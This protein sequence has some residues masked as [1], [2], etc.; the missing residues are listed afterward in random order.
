MRKATG[1]WITV[2]LLT[3]IINFIGCDSDSSSNEGEK[4]TEEF[5]VS[6][7]LSLPGGKS[8]TTGGY[9]INVNGDSYVNGTWSS[10][11]T[12]DYSF[13]IIPGTYNDI[14]INV[15]NSD[16]NL[17]YR[18]NTISAGLVV[19]NADI[20]DFNFNL[21]ETVTHTVSG[22]VNLPDPD[23]LSDG[24]IEIYINGEEYYDEPWDSGESLDYSFD[25]LSGTYN[26]IDIYAYNDMSELL[27]TY[28]TSTGGLV[29]AGDDVDNYDFTLGE[30]ETYTVSGNISLPAGE[31]ITDGY[32]DATF[33]G[34][35]RGEYSDSWSSGDTLAYSVEV[36]AGTYDN[37]LIE[38]SDE[39][40]T[41][42]YRY[43]NAA[44][45]LEVSADVTGYDFNL[46]E[47]E[48]FTVSGTITLPDEDMLTNGEFSIEIDGTGFGYDDGTWI[49]GHAA[50]YSIELEAGTYD[51]VEIEITDESET[52]LY[53]YRTNTQGL[54]IT[55]DTTV[56][57]TVVDRITY[58][59]S[60]TM[61]LPTGVILTNGH[62][63]IYFEGDVGRFAEIMTGSWT[64]GNS[65]QY[66]I[67]LES[68]SYF[69]I[70]I[71]V[72]DESWDIIYY[73]D[74]PEI[75]TLGSSDITGVDF[76]IE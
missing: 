25:I 24:V 16:G 8:L 14:E 1:L 36:E 22:T 18:Y 75:F 42:R 61:T 65:Q 56:N 68:G 58:T 54:T 5:T 26:D 52:I 33:A 17:L 45:G 7:T 67:E 6:G 38:V 41:V 31:E 63:D 4:D 57:F 13:E 43:T 59:V 21:T 44:E 73:Y 32:C 12:Q 60:G 72:Y 47:V 62:F 37:I 15:N 50:L 55:D 48:L 28:H 71:T 2:L 46:S 53:V 39:N 76:D 34:T 11:H 23:T 69:D 74:C 9:E 27:Y 29:V 70:G 20:D 30:T 51:E 35:S 19:A 10:G 64:G 3:A 66:S 40:E 49:S